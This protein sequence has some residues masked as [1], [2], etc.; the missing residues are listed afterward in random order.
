MKICK[1]CKKL[2]AENREAIIK[3]QLVLTD[4]IGEYGW[5][6]QTI[7]KVINILKDRNEKTK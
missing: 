4:M 6:K 1:T 5:R 2:Q 7:E 3:L